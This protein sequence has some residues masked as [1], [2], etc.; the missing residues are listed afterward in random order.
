M[1]QTR[2]LYPFLKKIYKSI[3]YSSYLDKGMHSILNRYASLYARVTHFSFP[4]KYG[5]EWKLEMLTHTYEKDTVTLLTTL[6]KPGMTVVDIGA[7]IGYYTRLFSQLTGEHGK[8]LAFE[9]DQ[10]NYS[11]LTHNTSHLTNVTR[12]HT[13]VSDTNEDISFFKIKHSTGCHS[14]ITPQGD[15]DTITVPCTTMDAYI[16]RTGITPEVIKMDIESGEPRALKGM[17]EY[18]AKAPYLVVLMEYS[19]HSL[20]RSGVDPLAFLEELE[21]YG[22]TISTILPHGVTVPFTKDDASSLLLYPTGYANLLCMKGHAPSKKEKTILH[23]APFGFN[24][25]LTNFVECVS[26]RLLA[27]E[28]WKV[29]A[30]TRQERPSEV[31]ETRYGVHIYRARSIYEGIRHALTLLLSSKVQ[32]I[33]IHHLRNNN[34]GL[35]VAVLA[36]LFRIPYLFTEYGLLHDPYIVKDRENPLAGPI[37]PEHAITSISKLFTIQNMS[38]RTRILSYI[39]HWPLA[40][41]NHVVLVSSHNLPLAS[42]MGLSHATYLPQ[43][44]DTTQWEEGSPLLKDEEKLARTRGTRYGIFVGQLKE[45]KGWD[46]F[47]RAIPLIPLDILPSFVVVTSTVDDAP[48]FF[49]DLVHELGIES[50]VIFLGQIFNRRILR[51]LYKKSEVIVVPSRYEGFGL[52]ITEAF[53]IERPLVACDVIAINET[54][55][56]GVNGILVEKENPLA[57]AQG[58]H[59]AL[60][61]KDATTRMIQE[62]TRTLAQF[63]SPHAY[64]QWI[65]FYEDFLERS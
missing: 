42:R 20:T 37:T 33:H 45:R 22:F 52:V 4:D 16:S 8:V 28:G 30:L 6:I 62:G 57:L 10:S 53:E 47:L 38:I 40:H 29:Y 15:Y 50:R 21:T 12:E 13:A 56:D 41:A 23:V 18:I 48:H 65:Q 43:I 54:V 24:A 7:H 26:A 63:T 36:K 27:S 9:A 60:S 51:E 44:L 3:P 59:R 1:G 11:L 31:T 64:A 19:P 34:L 55:R 5:W 25:R 32:I 58:I 14:V 39:Y 46:L 49:T 2:T 35:A 17:K 61:D